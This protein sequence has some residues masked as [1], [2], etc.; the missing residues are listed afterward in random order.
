MCACVAGPVADVVQTWTFAGDC[1]L[2]I[3]YIYMTVY[4][5]IYMCVCVCMMVHV[6]VWTGMG[7]LPNQHQ[8]VV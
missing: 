2:H 4:V 1:C 5:C 8:K 3:L 7:I 6:Y